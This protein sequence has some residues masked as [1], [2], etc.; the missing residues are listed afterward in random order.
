MALR[1]ELARAKRWP[2]WILERADF[3]P[4]RVDAP[5]RRCFVHVLASHASP[6]RRA[7]STDEALQRGKERNVRRVSSLVDG[8]ELAP[9]GRFSY[10]H[11]V[12]RPSRLRG[13]AEGLELHDGVPSRGIGGGSCQVSNLLYWLALTGGMK[14]LERHRH[15]LDLFRDD[16]R[17]VPFGCGATVFYNYADLR[18]ENP[19]AC[20]VLIAL[21]TD[22]THLYGELCSTAPL[23]LRVEVHERAHRFV[24][25][26]E[27]GGW[28][29]E[30]EIY[31]R[32][33]TPDGAL[34]REE[35]VGRNRGRVQYEPD[36]Q[37]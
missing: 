36:P 11:A 8:I 15:S 31:R 2:R 28:I 5:A 13:F 9:S 1:I 33:L 23:A 4:T 26:P 16:A 3:R 25:D 17:T 27:R 32:F 24:R 22:D 21:R 10:H 6:L 37:P 34:V 19:L 18:F 20:P 12:G 35:L 14:I 7:H 30:N 29:R